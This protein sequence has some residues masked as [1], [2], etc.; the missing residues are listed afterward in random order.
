MV[1]Q[2][3]IHP[4]N[5]ISFTLLSHPRRKKK[6]PKFARSPLYLLILEYANYEELEALLILSVFHY[7]APSACN[8]GVSN[9]C[10]ALNILPAKSKYP[11]SLFCP[12]DE[13]KTPRGFRMYA[14]D[15]QIRRRKTSQIYCHFV[16]GAKFLRNPAKRPSRIGLAEPLLRLSRT[17]IR[18]YFS[19]DPDEGLIEPPRRRVFL[20]AKLA[21]EL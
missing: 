20:P 6:A 16:G 14:S 3:L 7:L 8:S 9:I 13:F 17:G 1:K 10:T 5:L 15:G 2:A 19:T 11:R 18:N 12:R 4:R 21:A